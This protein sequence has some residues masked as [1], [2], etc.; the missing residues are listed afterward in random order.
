VVH[1]LRAEGAD[2]EQGTKRRLQ[3][4]KAAHEVMEDTV[5]HCSNAA[6]LL[7]IVNIS[8]VLEAD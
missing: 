5:S 8:V 2:E 7:V 4:R 1:F 6:F 3:R